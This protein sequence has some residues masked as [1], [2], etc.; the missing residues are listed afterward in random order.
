MLKIGFDAKRFFDN[1]TGLGVYSRQLVQ[2]LCEYYPQNEYSLFY[3]GRNAE[4]N[5]TCAKVISKPSGNYMP[6]WAWRSFGQSKQI[7]Q[8]KID[9]YHGLSNELPFLVKNKTKMVVTMHDVLWLRF[10][11]FYSLPDRKVYS[12]KAQVALRKA[13]AVIATSKQTAEDLIQFFKVDEKK[14]HVV[15]QSVNTPNSDSAN[16]KPI[17][18][19]EYL[20]Y[21]SSFQSRKN[22][23]MLIDGFN[24]VKNNLNGKLVLA[25]RPFETYK[26]C[27]EKVKEY[28][29]ENKVIFLTD[30]TESEIANLYSHASGFVYPSMFE[31]F[32]IPLVEAIEYGL[33]IAASNQSIFKEV[34]GNT[35]IYFEPNN[36][37]SIADLLLRLGK[38]DKESFKIRYQDVLK[39]YNKELISKQLMT[40]Y[41]GL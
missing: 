40:I 23:L 21:V 33:P 11:Q 32:G 10:P 7:N 5:K 18:S 30:T 29:L 12:L 17:I 4:N 15:Y 3:A 6:D 36:A 27:I 20:L 26:K 1:A 25:G 2:M 13:D 37:Y 19:G 39:K 31:G 24:M 41:N 14:I 35:A 34:T 16:E 38:V 22:H 9:I 28:N 8:N